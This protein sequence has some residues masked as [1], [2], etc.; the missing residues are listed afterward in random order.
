[1]M[2][3]FQYLVSKVGI[4]SL[5]QLSFTTPLLISG[6]SALVVAIEW[7]V[8]SYTKKIASHKEGITN[9]LS[10]ALTY[11]PL[12]FLNTFFTVSLM[13]LFYNNRLFDL[14]FSW[15]IWVLAYIT[16]DFMSFLIHFLS[17][18]VRLFWCIHSVHHSAKEMKTTVTFRTSFAKFL[19]APHVTLWLPL[20]GFHPLMFV[21]VASF[22]QLYA[23][24]LHFNEKLLLKS[25]INLPWIKNIFITPLTHRLYHA[26]DDIY[27]DTNYGITFSIWDRVFKTY[28]DEV[29]GKKIVFGLTKEIDSENLLISQ[30]D[31]FKNLW[32]DIKKAPRLLDKLKYMVYSPGWNHLDGGITAKGIREMNHE[33]NSK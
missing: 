29:V 16:F 9:L 28:Q 27:L 1:M 25:K 4:S 30:T 15:Y 23:L 21:I 8:L 17:H 2:F 32:Q 24:R 10:A 14:G 6:V 12:F 18:K 31:E 20:L 3:D 5:E 22:E 19:L 33:N 26:T 13:Y 11:Y 7:I